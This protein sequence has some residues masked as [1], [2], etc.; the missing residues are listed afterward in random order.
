MEAII[1]ALISAVT[2]IIAAWIV[3]RNAKQAAINSKP[4]SNG[5]TAHVLDEFAE[6]RER[7]AALSAKFDDHLAWSREETERLWLAIG[8]SSR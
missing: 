5:F 3:N 6:S 7:D 8:R 2:T 1:V 4:V